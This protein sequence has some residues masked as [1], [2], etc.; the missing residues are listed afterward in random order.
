MGARARRVGH[1]DSE[2]DLELSGPGSETWVV[3][4]VTP[5]ADSDFET[6]VSQRRSLIFSEGE[7]RQYQEKRYFL[8]ESDFFTVSFATYEFDFGIAGKYTYIVLVS[9]LETI[10]GLET[11]SLER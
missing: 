6:V 11:Y 4:Y 1:R 10:F 7:P 8:E 2:S 9:E 5:S 3:S